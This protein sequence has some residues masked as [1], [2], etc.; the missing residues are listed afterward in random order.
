MTVTGLLFTG[1]I[2][3]Y[4]L[5]VKKKSDPFALDVVRVRHD[6]DVTIFVPESLLSAAPTPRH[7]KAFYIYGGTS[8]A[9]VC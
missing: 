1:A 4:T 9:C 2:G 8:L 7:E 3:Y 5:Y 6:L